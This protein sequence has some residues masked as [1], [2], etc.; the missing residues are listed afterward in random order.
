MSDLKKPKAK[1]PKPTFAQTLRSSAKP[2]RQLLPYLRPYRGRF[3]LGLLLGAAFG[4]VNGLLPLVMREVMTI[5][6]GGKGQ[7]SEMVASAT[8][9]PPKDKLPKGSTLYEKA[10]TAMVNKYEKLK[11]KDTTGPKIDSALTLCA[12]IPFIMILRGLL[13]Y[14]SSYFMA[15]VSLRVL[16]DLRDDVYKHVMKQSLDFFH[17]NKSGDL[18][19]RVYNDPRMA[20][21]ALSTISSDLVTQP[22]AILMAVSVLVFIDW[23]FTLI[24]LCLFPLCL[25]PVLHYGRRVRKGGGTEEDSASGMM[26]I[27]QESFAGIRVI[28]SLAR[29][30]HQIEKF[31]E[32]NLEQFHQSFRIRQTVEAVGPMVESVSAI[33]AGVTI[34]YVW[35]SGISVATFISMLMGLFL[36]Y[37]PMKKLSRIHVTMQRTFGATAKIFDILDSKPLVLDRPNAVAISHAKGHLSFNDIT[38][39]YRKDRNAVVDIQFDF[40]AGK[41]YALVGESG[42]GKSTMMALILRFYEP[43]SGFIQLDGRDIRDITQTSLREQIGVVT[44]ETFLFHDTIA[45]NIRYGRFEATDEEVIQAAKLAHADEFIIEQPNGYQTVIGDKGC[46]ISGGQQQRLAIARA[47]L[48]NAPIL[49]LDEATS[50]LDSESE[51]AIQSALEL[52]ASGRTVIAIAHRLSTILKADK[53]IVMKDGRIAEVGSHEEL[54]TESTIYRRLYNIQ[55]RNSDMPADLEMAS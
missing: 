7:K 36:L 53:I 24:S 9:A 20:Q 45:N 38:F 18:I 10:R 12:A 30:R 25:L 26:V 8:I 47:L 4:V 49:L 13:S 50:A 41:Y 48:K 2:V 11:V 19:S 32:S 37:D 43:N 17:K 21:M 23:K 52:L 46:M 1:K 55:F 22:I 6:P 40:E 42:A 27:L 44:Q 35:Y 14:F 54:L 5:V 28:K 33:G 34:F 29:E 39:A 51:L 16:S 15:W 3:I 31:A